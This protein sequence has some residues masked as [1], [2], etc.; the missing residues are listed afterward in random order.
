VPGPLV[1]RPA[2]VELTPRLTEHCPL[3]SVLGVD[4]PR[5]AVLASG[6]GTNLQA[7]L[8]HPVVAPWI[9][10]VVSDRQ[11][12]R[13]LERARDRGVAAVFLDPSEH[14]EP[15][16]F[17]AAL[18]ANLDA[19][20]AGFIV[21]AGYLRILGPDVIRSYEGRIV[22]VHPA[23]LPAFPGKHA[24]EDALEWGVK[25]TGVTIH[26][27]DEQVDHGPIVAQ[28]AVAVIPG[29]DREALEVRVHEVEHRLLPEAVLALVEGRLEVDRRVVRVREAAR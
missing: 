10:L 15:A 2:P 20:K 8:D 27:V 9:H 1:P 3:R 12:A 22:N 17:D 25:V 11:S 6:E 29:E 14:A 5:I 4:Q 16:D 18:L 13:A 19:A 26:L 21:L 7:L 23:L 24:V 28:E